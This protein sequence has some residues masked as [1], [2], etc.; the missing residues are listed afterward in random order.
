MTSASAVYHLQADTHKPPTLVA[1]VNAYM[2]MRIYYHV[3][4]AGDDIQVSLVN[5][6]FS[7]VHTV[8]EL[9]GRY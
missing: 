3:L 2:S 7:C 5:V 4:R 9:K 1:S 6:I 8:G